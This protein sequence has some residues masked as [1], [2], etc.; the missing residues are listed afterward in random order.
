[1][2]I[3]A[4]QGDS[5]TAESIIPARSAN[6]RR[7]GSALMPTIF[8]ASVVWGLLAL[9]ALHR[10]FYLIGFPQLFPSVL[11]SPSFASAFLATTLLGG[12]G[13]LVTYFWPPLLVLAGSWFGEPPF[14]L[15]SS[16]ATDRVA[17]VGFLRNVGYFLAIFIGYLVIG[18]LN[19]PYDLYWTIASLAL[20]SALT[21]TLWVWYL[22]R[23]DNSTRGRILD[24]NLLS[25]FFGRL[26]G[27]F[28]ILLVLLMLRD[29]GIEI[30]GGLNQLLYFAVFALFTSIAYSVL[31]SGSQGLLHAVG[32]TLDVRITGSL[33][34]RNKQE[35]ESNDPRAIAG[36]Q[37]E[38][39]S[40]V[41]GI[42]AEV[43]RIRLFAAATIPLVAFAL[44]VLPIESDRLVLNAAR[45]MGLGGRSQEFL[46]ASRS[47]GPSF[48]KRANWAY[49]KVGKYVVVNAYSPFDG[50][51]LVV[52]C[53]KYDCGETRRTHVVG[54][55]LVL[56]RNE[57]RRMHLVGLKFHIKS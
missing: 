24:G 46:I 25:D 14:H 6:W 42:L 35:V 27:G 7:L 9:I 36:L 2:E 52:L 47:V 41:K 28:A 19:S 38:G 22:R 56:R 11:T 4:P 34:K 12:M 1:M 16:V 55:Y 17:A 23:S 5:E 13:F 53:R 45:A 18:A 8:K 57:V 26:V 31:I 44:L 3:E 39:H 29:I 51:G 49:V 15:R 40:M 43:G 37:Q 33:T 20:V 32:E 21:A 50:A 54:E 10:Y 30:S 48:L